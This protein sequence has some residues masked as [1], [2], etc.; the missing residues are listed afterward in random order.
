MVRLYLSV[1]REELDL[2]NKL[3]HVLHSVTFAN[4]GLDRS[5]SKSASVSTTLEAS[6]NEAHPPDL[7][8]DEFFVR[9][10]S[11]AIAQHNN[12]VTHH[13]VDFL[14]MTIQQFRRSLQTVLLPLIDCLCARLAKLVRDFQKCY[15]VSNPDAPMPASS[16]TD[17][18]FTVLTNALERL[19]L[20]AVAETAPAGSD[21]DARSTTGGL[22][23]DASSSAT[24]GGGGGLLGYMTGVLSHQELD[25][26]DVPEQVKVHLGSLASRA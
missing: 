8:R 7:T 19:L 9:I 23:N 5:H 2:Q 24:G 3:L 26:A 22:S 11:D 13:W 14:L 6:A 10:V 20:M 17:A 21:D 4:G 1:H 12:A 15:T 25:S 18:E 16:T